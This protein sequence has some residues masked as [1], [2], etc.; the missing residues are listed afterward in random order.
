MDLAASIHRVTEE[1]VIKAATF[2]KEITGLTNL[3]LAGG[4]VLNCVANGKLLQEKIFDHIWIQ[5][6]A[7]DIGGALGAAYYLYYHRWDRLRI[8]EARDSE[9]GSY[10]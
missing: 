4:I 8:P 1:I 3:C 9:K 10:L 5:P 2:A 6:A 7:E